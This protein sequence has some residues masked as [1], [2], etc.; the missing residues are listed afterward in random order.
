MSRLIARPFVFITSLLVLSLVG[1]LW[2]QS[3]NVPTKKTAGKAEKPVVTEEKP[4]AQGDNAAPVVEIVPNEPVSLVSARKVGTIDM[5]EVLL[6]VAGTAKQVSLDQKQVTEP[7]QVIAG[8]RYEERITQSALSEKMDGKSLLKSLRS[9][10]L[11]KAK[12]SIGDV[13]KTP[14]LDANH[15]TIVYGINGSETVLFCPGGPLQSEQLLLLEGMPGNSLSLD[16]L[17]PDKPVKIG[18]S[19]KISEKPLRSFLNLDSVAEYDLKAVLVSVVDDLA[20]IEI[21]GDVQGTY[22]GAFTEMSVQAKYQFDLRINRINWL[23]MLID[24]K[25]AIGHVGPGLDLKASVEVKI[26]PIT[27]P[28]TLTDD[29]LVETE[30]AP[31]EMVLSLRYDN[32]RGPWRFRHPRSWYIIQDNDNSTLLRLMERGELIAQCNIVSMPSVN[33]KSLTSLKSF[34]E[35]IKKGLGTNFA[36]IVAQEESVNAA[37]YTEYRVIIDGQVQDAEKKVDTFPLRWVY[38]LLT[39]SLG[40]QTVLAFVIH[41]EMLER[42][43]SNDEQIIDTLRMIDRTNLPQ[44]KKV[45]DRG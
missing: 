30:L 41:A 25:R 7:M 36:G 8:F 5:V 39:D 3:P 31:N 15:Q 28:D 6:K 32:G 40:N 10:K 21:V 17:L 12:M 22:L 33:P 19:W 44:L 27:E 2:G 45:G 14:E 16:L 43:G 20:M 37:G 13:L 35:D 23:G 1:T 9:Y 38:Y 42:F 26:S 18:D 24:E 29:F 4:V 11:A 34:A